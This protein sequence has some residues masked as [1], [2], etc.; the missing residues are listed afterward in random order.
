MTVADL[1]GDNDNDPVDFWV[2]LDLEK[3]PASAH[4]ARDIG[5]RF[6][7]SGIECAEG[8]LAPRYTTGS[9]CVVCSHKQA[10]DKRD[11]S[12]ARRGKQGAARAH[13]VRAIAMIDGQKTYRPSRPCKHGHWLRWVGTNNCIECEEIKKA[14]YAEARREA[15]LVKLYGITA[16]GFTDMADSQNQACKICKEVVADRS[17]FHVDHC[18]DTGKVRGL[19]CSKCNQAIGL[20]RDN[21]DLMRAAAN[22]VEE[23]RSINAAA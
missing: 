13:L 12:G 2:G 5:C 19:L 17:Q 14:G 6:F 10:Q 9:K 11:G 20:L 1:F 22:Y 21:P 23:H 7:F 8:H 18:H 15:R 3:L 4:A 16:S